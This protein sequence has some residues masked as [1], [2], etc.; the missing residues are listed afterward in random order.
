MYHVLTFIR[1][2]WHLS[3]KCTMMQYH[4]MQFF[5]CHLSLSKCQNSGARYVKS[6]PVTS[7]WRPLHSKHLG[8]PLSLIYRLYK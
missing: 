1:E 4:E 2:T 6:W 5:L 3:R 7:S 8:A